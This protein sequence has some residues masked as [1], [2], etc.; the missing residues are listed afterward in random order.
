[1]APTRKL[2]SILLLHDVLPWP[3]W[4]NADE[5]NRGLAALD[6]FGVADAEFVPYYAANP[7]AWVSQPGLYVSGYRRDKQSLLIVANLSK[8]TISD[9]LCLPGSDAT[10][11][12]LSWP[13]RREQTLVDRCAS[14]SLEAG[15]YATYQVSRGGLQ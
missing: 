3:F 14:I 8:K 7:L 6:Q 15:S 1:V 4:S 11:R 9:Q 12:L 10:A 5:V 2:M 13:D